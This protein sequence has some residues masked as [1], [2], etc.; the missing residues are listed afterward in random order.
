LGR[1]FEKQDNM[2]VFSVK[3]NQGGVL[4]NFLAYKDNDDNID[5]KIY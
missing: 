2:E 1:L 4:N 3:N 5:G